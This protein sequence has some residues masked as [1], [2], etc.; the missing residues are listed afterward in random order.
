MKKFF[1]IGNGFDIQHGI[2][3]KYSDFHAFM[4]SIYMNE[5]IRDN[6]FNDFFP[7]CYAVPKSR[8]VLGKFDNSELIN[9]FG[10]L[11]YCLTKSENKEAAFNFLNNPE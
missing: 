10:F 2:K 6:S 1:I 11:D 9:V 5:E 3:S 7:W 8:G 4:R